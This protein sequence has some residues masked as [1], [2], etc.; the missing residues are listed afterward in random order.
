M[1]HTVDP[2]GAAVMRRSR[3]EIRYRFEPI[4]RGGR[5]LVT[6]KN[7]EALRAIHVFLRFQI[8]DHETGDPATLGADAPPAPR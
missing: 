4:E 2:P 6:T 1:I 8:E 7:A 5:V 3:T